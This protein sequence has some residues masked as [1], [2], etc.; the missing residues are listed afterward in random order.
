MSFN[1]AGQ[2]PQDDKPAG[3]GFGIGGPTE[4]PLSNVTYTGDLSTDAA[5]EFKEIA[6][7]YRKRA[8]R[9]VDR[10]RAATD[11]EYWFCVYFESREQVE[12]FQRK[13]GIIPRLHGDKYVSGPAFAELLGVDL[14]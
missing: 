5:N 8:R 9:E 2:A 1:F 13:V 4:D 11:S 10:K 14:D 12:Q 6:S 3:A 7:A